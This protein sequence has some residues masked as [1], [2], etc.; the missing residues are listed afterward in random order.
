MDN[1]VEYQ[2]FEYNEETKLFK[3]SD[4]ITET[5]YKIDN[6]LE[7]VQY[8]VQALSYTAISYNVYPDNESKNIDSNTIKTD[9]TEEN[10]GTQGNNNYIYYV[11][12][13]S[14]LVIVVVGVIVIVVKK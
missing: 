10:I 4:R 6:S 3:M 8:I 9:A 1:A 13:V 14:G 5:S 2:I 12:C 7:N 11:I